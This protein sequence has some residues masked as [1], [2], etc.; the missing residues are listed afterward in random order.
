M[1]IILIDRA[2]HFHRQVLNLWTKNLH[3]SNNNNLVNL[4]MKI[5]GINKIS[6][7]IKIHFETKNKK[8]ITEICNLIISIGKTSHK[9]YL[10]KNLWNSNYL[11]QSLEPEIKN[12]K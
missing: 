8:M 7:V 12:F 4:I 6:K 11:H 3:K 10:Q 9:M 2:I 5:N 1:Y